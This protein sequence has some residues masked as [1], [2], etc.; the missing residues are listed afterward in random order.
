MGGGGFL[1]KYIFSIYK[2]GSLQ[3]RLYIKVETYFMDK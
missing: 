3:A 1:I 2:S